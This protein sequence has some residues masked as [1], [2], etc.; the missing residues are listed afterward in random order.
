[1]A[2]YQHAE[3]C[4]RLDVSL[5]DLSD[6][7]LH[8]MLALARDRVF[9]AF[10]F[11]R[12]FY[13]GKW[14]PTDNYIASLGPR[15]QDLVMHTAELCHRRHKHFV[16]LALVVATY[17]DLRSHVKRIA[18][19]LE[20]QLLRVTIE[21]MCSSR[22]P[23]CELWHEDDGTWNVLP[24]SVD[25]HEAIRRAGKRAR[26]SCKRDRRNFHGRVRN[27]ARRSGGASSIGY[28]RK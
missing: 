2:R 1:M 14:R 24:S 4:Y 13:R 10:T 28:Q 26:K 21:E 20:I 6:G 16:P 9:Y 18:N 11:A 17:G 8:D 22:P 27:Q 25:A 23:A 19:E 12:I 3:V 15:Q 5:D 7:N